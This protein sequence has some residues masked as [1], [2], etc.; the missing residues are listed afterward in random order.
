[1]L[2]VGFELGVTFQTLR[3]D[4]DAPHSNSEGQRVERAVTRQ[5]E[6][7]ESAKSRVQD[8]KASGELN[9]E[10]TDLLT[11]K[12]EEINAQQVKDPADRPSSEQR[13]SW[14]DW[15]GEHELPSKYLS[16]LY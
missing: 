14:R 12:I 10:Q 13:K 11:A 8:G 2:L 9:Q 4:N 15:L 7:Y 16:P 3:V 1:M 5:K 6:G